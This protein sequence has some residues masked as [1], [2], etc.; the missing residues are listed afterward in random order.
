MGKNTRLNRKIRRKER[1][2]KRKSAEQAY[3]KKMWEEGKKLIEPEYSAEGHYPADYSIELGKR[4]VSIIQGFRDRVIK[5]GT[6]H[7]PRVPE[8]VEKYLGPNDR[9]IYFF[10]KYRIKIR[11]F[12]ILYNPD[13]PETNEFLYL[14]RA[15]ETYWD[16][17]QNLL[18]VL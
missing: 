2:E 9:I 16:E 11:N 4:L 6:I 12:I 10:R 13:I 14:K 17:P 8:D 18:N 7:D 3:K 5:E 15:I 1:H